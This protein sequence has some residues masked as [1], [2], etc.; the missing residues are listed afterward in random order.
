MSDISDYL[1]QRGLDLDPIKVESDPILEDEDRLRE[2]ADM[3]NEHQNALRL[4]IQARVNAIGKHLLNKAIPQETI[5][6]RQALVE[7]G[8]IVDDFV[9]YSSEWERR[10]KKVEDEAETPP[11]DNEGTL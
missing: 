3:W 11:A 5:V 10:S 4:V 6:L 1:Y 2:A 9:K 8:A 7:V